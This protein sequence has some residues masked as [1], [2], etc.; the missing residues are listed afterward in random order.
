MVFE[1]VF[2]SFLSHS[3]LFCFSQWLLVKSTWMEESQCATCKYSFHFIIVSL[4]GPVSKIKFQHFSFNAHDFPFLH[5]FYCPSLNLFISAIFFIRPS[6]QAEH[7]I[8]EYPFRNSLHSVQV[9]PYLNNT[10]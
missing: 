9:S 2:P 1:T 10:D 7:I 8:P 4:H 3:L 5:D 6:G